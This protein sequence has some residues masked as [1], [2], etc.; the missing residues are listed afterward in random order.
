MNAVIIPALNPDEHLVALVHEL[1]SLGQTAI[2]VVND[3]SDAEHETVFRRLEI[4]G[5][6]VCHHAA[7][8]GKGEAIR[9][10]I[11]A[12]STS[13]S[14][15]GIGG[16]VTADADGQHRARDIVSVS[17]A[18]DAHP[19]TIVLGMRD[20][21]EGNVP[22]QRSLSNRFSSFFFRLS[23]GVTCPD[24]QTGLR[25]FSTRFTDFSLAVPGSRYEYEMNFLSS[26][27]KMRIP[28]T[29]VPIETVYLGN[30][31]SSHFRPIAD[32]AR[33]YKVP[34]RF[35]GASIS[36]ALVDLLI[37]TLIT[38]TMS[39]E[40]YALVLLATVAARVL[41]GTLN[42]ALNRRWAFNT[43]QAWS[44]Q[45]ARYLTLF[46]FQMI[47]SWLL[48]WCF[49]FLPVPLALIKAVVD[50]TLFVISYMIQRDWVFAGRLSSR[51]GE[52]GSG[53]PAT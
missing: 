38:Q 30:N 2:V 39:A 50:G 28:F 35:A 6:L 20:F 3:G 16:Y 37:F 13:G 8:M 34:L 4:A 29:M 10:G 5:C 40:G 53:R 18:L 47:A 27:A 24:T 11:R 15:R 17:E 44:P 33:I 48:V 9:T 49:S 22:R 23:T 7:N 25:G 36:C 45:A 41:S 1:Q 51:A 46:L 21:R 42:F 31:E 32:T 14:M 43:S 19:E 26:A 12:V 52:A